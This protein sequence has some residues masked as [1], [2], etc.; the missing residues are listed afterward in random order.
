MMT[1]ALTLGQQ[2][3]YVYHTRNY[4]FR[5]SS[6]GYSTVSKINSRTITLA[7][8]KEFDLDGREKENGKK[9]DWGASGFE[10]MAV[11]ELQSRLAEEHASKQLKA[12]MIAFLTA[13]TDSVQ[14]NRNGLGD[15]FAMTAEERNTLQRMLAEM[16]VRETT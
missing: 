6:H 1:A 9:R 2:I 5:L 4:G 14:R 16:P 3:A 8:G 10:L 15:Q 11:E 13:A 12:K 7:N